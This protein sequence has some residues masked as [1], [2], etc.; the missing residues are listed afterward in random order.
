MRILDKTQDKRTSCSLWCDLFSTINIYR[1][2]INIVVKTTKEG[3]NGSVCFD[4]VNSGTQMLLI[5]K[6]TK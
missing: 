5:N 4:G 2:W 3:F 1:Q 6:Q